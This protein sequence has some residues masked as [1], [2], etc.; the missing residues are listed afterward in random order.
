MNL[1]CLLAAVA[2]TGLLLPAAAASDL[3]SSTPFGQMTEDYKRP[4]EVPANFFNP[5][6]VQI[7]AR[8][9]DHGTVAV[10]D[11]SLRAALSQRGLS[12][13]VLAASAAD[14]RAIIGDEVFG[15]GEEL[16]FTDD[17]GG[18]APLVANASVV[19]RGITKTSLVL[20]LTCGGESPRTVSFALRSFLRP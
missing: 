3:A 13:L 8:G 12:G 10:S 1:R 2:M 4:F 9:D 7:T 5:F 11:D 6:K 16:Q 15:V 18:T 17:K 14:S 19:L 20:E